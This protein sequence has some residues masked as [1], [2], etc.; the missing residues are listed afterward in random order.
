MNTYV[1]VKKTNFS[2][3]TS[4]NV[5]HQS[6]GGKRL[7]PFMDQTSGILIRNSVPEESGAC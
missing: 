5:I 7:R 3:L 1:N 6:L 4:E 2:N